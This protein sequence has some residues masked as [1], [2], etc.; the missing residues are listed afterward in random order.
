MVPLI[1]CLALN[2]NLEVKEMANVM[3]EYYAEDDVYQESLFKEIQTKA[4]EHSD[5]EIEELKVELK[6]RG[7]ILVDIAMSEDQ[8]YDWQADQELKA[9][10]FEIEK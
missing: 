10:G 9:A 7:F 3:I 4:D 8:Y 6:E 1:E 5:D 2:K